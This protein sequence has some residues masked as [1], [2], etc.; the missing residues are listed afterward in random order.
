[1]LVRRPADTGFKSGDHSRQAND[2]KYQFLQVN[3]VENVKDI[4][5]KMKSSN[6]D[7][8]INHWLSVTFS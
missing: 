4:D 5:L 7:T 1:M 2:F 3:Y 6:I 8:S